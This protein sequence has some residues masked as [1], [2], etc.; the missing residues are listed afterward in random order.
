[1][2]L[3]SLLAKSIG[4]SVIIIIIILKNSCC[5]KFLRSNL[6]QT[7]EPDEET[8]QVHKTLQNVELCSLI[9]FY[10]LH[11]NDCLKISI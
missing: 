11:S 1:M 9:V 2:P 8:W 7:V 5:L 6:T 4:H 10:H 3:M